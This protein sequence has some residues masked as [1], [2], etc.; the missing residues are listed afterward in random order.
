MNKDNFSVSR[1]DF[2]KI[3]AVSTG[4]LIIGFYLPAC[5]ARSDSLDISSDYF[6]PNAWLSIDASGQVT[7]TLGKSEM[8]QGVTTAL[9]TLI[10]EELEVELATI[11]IELAK[12]HPRFGNQYTGGST[13][14]QE[15]WIILRKVGAVS[16]LML[17]AAA[18]KKWNVVTDDCYALK[19]LVYHKP[20]ERH[21]TYG[22]L[23]AD[24][25]KQAIPE[26]VPLKKPAEF[27]LI[28]RHAPRLD[29]PDKVTGRARF[30][31]DVELPNMLVATIVHP[32][33]FGGQVK[34]YD[35]APALSV[36]GV[37]HVLEI[38]SGIAV[39]ADGFWQAMQGLKKLTIQW[40]TDSNVNESSADIDSRYVN[41]SNNKGMLAFEKGMPLRGEQSENLTE[42]ES[43]YSL[44]YQAHA[45]MEPMNCVA[46]VNDKGCEVWA[47]T[48][49]PQDARY[50]VARHLYGNIERKLRRLHGKLI[51]DTYP[52]I[53]IHTT[54]IGCG[55]GR[56]L[57]HDF[58]IE[59]VQISKKLKVPVKLIW[60]REEDMRH[61]YYRPGTYNK[62]RAKL[63][64]DG[65]PLEWYHKIICPAKGRSVDGS[66]NIPYSIP[67]IRIDYLVDET[68]VPIGSW[69]STGGS[70]NA[71]VIECF[72][73]EI[74][75]LN[76]FDPYK[77]RVSLLKDKPKHKAVLEAATRTA[78]WGRHNLSSKHFLG[79]ALYEARNSIVAQ[80]A[81]VSMSANN[82]VHVHK[83]VCAV[84]C[85]TVV[86]EDIVKSQI[87]GGIVFGLN[88]VIKNEITIQNGGVKQSNFDDFPLLRMHETPE[89]EVVIIYD[90]RSP[91]GVGE[92]GV[93]PIAPAVV[94]AVFAATGKR[95]RKL[96]IRNKHF[97]NS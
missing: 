55:F 46:S 63:G 56:R 24:A 69:R 49:N 10:A 25:A 21:F 66:E 94:N 4:S 88:A 19:G 39:V 96:P 71:F 16:R 68:C 34:A 30:G 38:E 48:Q 61:G 45:T 20:S 40:S 42:I 60:S 57:E 90:D 93:S 50:A 95:I 11:N 87:E 54:F 33:F 7:I 6:S 91:G 36:K 62:L 79:L 17:I 44:P 97:V 77:F 82:E 75:S 3:G 8:G 18:A 15:N 83:V 76:K 5:N 84:N 74:A 67:H 22:E 80:V 89:I 47:P 31:I 85:G 53:T 27:H 70:L 35:A 51:G 23:I 26:N 43:S 78:G 13:S 52:G 12:A 2:I 65:F 92:V 73:D 41:I 72:I 9:P 81:E 28:G 58:I 14:V 86:N 29:I 59:A 37:R 32:P 1:R 64:M